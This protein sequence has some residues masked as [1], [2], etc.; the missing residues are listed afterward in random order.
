MDRDTNKEPGL[1]RPYSSIP[2]SMSAGAV[3]FISGAT[4]PKAAGINGPYD[5]T[6][7]ISGGYA[8]YSKR[9]EPSMCIEH[10]D[11]RWQLKPVSDK[12]KNGCFAY[13]AGGCALE[14]CA[15]RVWRVRN[16]VCVH[17]E[18]YPISR[19]TRAPVPGLMRALRRQR[20]VQE[21]GHSIHHDIQQLHGVRQHRRE[22]RQQSARGRQF[23]RWNCSHVH[24]WLQVRCS[25]SR[26]QA[27]R[28][29]CIVPCVVW[30]VP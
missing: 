4:G 26:R 18:F 24:R 23:S 1:P 10:R 6:G 8:V 12:R 16:G 30:C 15:S 28:H 7:E 13:V 2:L 27:A 19:L 22:S 9:G 3:V 17:V 25:C 5:R 29:V 14:D 11:G 21:M 20:V